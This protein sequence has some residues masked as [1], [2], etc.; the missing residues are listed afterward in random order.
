MHVL[1]KWDQRLCYKW[2]LFQ[3]T[4][5]KLKKVNYIFNTF[6]FKYDTHNLFLFINSQLNNY[7]WLLEF[8]EFYIIDLS[9]YY[10]KFFF[11]S[12]CS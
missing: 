9:K 8:I 1:L 10:K 12:T 3:G 11:I 4:G 7:F 6:F 2:L 5:Q